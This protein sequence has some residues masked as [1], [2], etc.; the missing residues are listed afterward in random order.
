MTW[1]MLTLIFLLVVTEGLMLYQLF[2][3]V[4]LDAAARGMKHPRFW[5][6]FTAGGQHG[7]GLPTYLLMRNKAIVSMTAEEKEVFQIRKRRVLYLLVLT[8]IL[9]IF[10]IST[11]IVN[12]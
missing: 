6:F 5:A 4:E 3:L 7:E 11:F 1:Y 2:K 10:L 12:F 9:G 8:F